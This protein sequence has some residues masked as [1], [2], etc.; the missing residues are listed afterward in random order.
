MRSV[1]QLANASTSIPILSSVILQ[2]LFLSLKDQSLAFLAGIWTSR[3]E[4]LRYLKTV[5]LLH[6]VAFLEAHTLEDDGMD[7][8]TILPSILVALLDS[9]D[10]LSQ[11][12]FE[13]ISRI[14]VLAERPL[15]SVYEFDVIYGP[16]DSKLLLTSSDGF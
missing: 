11:A 9:D 16:S 2:L 5:A 13:C 8:Q 12:A 7:F 15:H 3:E 1:Y 4:G 10:Q 14:W 6:A